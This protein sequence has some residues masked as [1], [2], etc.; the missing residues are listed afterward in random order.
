MIDFLVTSI[1]KPLYFLNTC[2]I[3]DEVAKLGK[4]TKDTYD[5]WFCKIFWIN[6][7]PKV[8]LSKSNTKQNSDISTTYDI[9]E[10][11]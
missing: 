11:Y 6:G 8:S 10:Q 9:S 2:L 7:L 3:F 5:G 1:S 4:A